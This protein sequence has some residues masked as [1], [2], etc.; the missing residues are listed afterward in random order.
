MTDDPH[1]AQKKSHFQPT[2]V[3]AYN[4]R[5][6]ALGGCVP[7]IYHEENVSDPCITDQ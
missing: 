7:I 6:F 5:G 3:S 2:Q 4:V 1:T